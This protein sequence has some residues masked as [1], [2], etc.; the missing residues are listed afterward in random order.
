MAHQ[1]CH[2]HTGIQAASKGGAAFHG[3]TALAL[4]IPRLGLGLG[5]GPRLGP[6]PDPDAAPSFA[7]P[8]FALVDPCRFTAPSSHR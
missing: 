4:T 7:A 6:Y 5:L 8:S 3:G 1:C 2:S